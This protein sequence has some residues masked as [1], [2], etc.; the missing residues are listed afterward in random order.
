MS[1]LDVLDIYPPNVGPPHT[2]G[3]RW[4]CKAIK[5]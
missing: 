4:P 1:N 3:R 5:P 2:H